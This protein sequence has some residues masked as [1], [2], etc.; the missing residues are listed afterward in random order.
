MDYSQ[1]TNR[2]DLAKVAYTG[3]YLDLTNHPGS[4]LDNVIGTDP[5]R[6]TTS[7]KFRIVELYPAYSTRD[8]YLTKEDWVKFDSKLSFDGKWSSLTEVPLFKQ[9]AFSG[10]YHDLIN[11]PIIEVQDLSSYL[12]LGDTAANSLLLNGLPY[13]YFQPAGTSINGSG[14]STEIA[15]FIN[16]NTI[17]SSASLTWDGT[18]LVVGGNIRAQGDVLAFDGAAPINWWL[19]MPIAEVG[20]IGGVDV[21][22]DDTLFLNGKGNWSAAGSGGSS[23]TWPGGPGIAVYSGSSSWGTS[24]D[25]ANNTNNYLTTMTGTGFNGEAGLT[26][27]GSILLATGDIKA[28]GR[29][30]GGGLVNL[31]TAIMQG[32]IDTTQSYQQFMSFKDEAGTIMFS[33]GNGVAAGGYFPVFTGKVTSTYPGLYFNGNCVNGPGSGNPIVVFDGRVNNAAASATD[34]I[35]GFSSGYGNLKVTV[36]G[37]GDL[38]TTGILAAT[39]G[40]ST[41]WNTAYT[42]RNKWDGG[43]SGLTA[44]TGRSSLGLGT[45]A[46]E[47]V[48]YFATAS[49]GS[50]GATAYG[51]GN[52]ASVGYYIG[53]GSAFD[54]AGAASGAVG[55]HESTYNHSNFQDA[56]NDR[57]K[58]DGGS[59]GLTAATGRT[60]LGLGSAAQNNTGDFVAYRTFGSA[61]NNNT[62]DFVAYRTFND[63]NWDT[64]YT[65]RMKWDG[66]DTGLTASTGRT[67]LGLNNVTNESK[68]TMF[69][70]PVFTTSFGF[71]SGGWRFVESGTDILF[72][73]NN[74]TKATLFSNGNLTCTG[75]VTA[76]G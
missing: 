49:Q 9:V 62:G 71:S 13:N 66:G 55:S 26:Y 21:P 74:V 29:V 22:N 31:S 50:Q 76:F 37:N 59:T 18:D 69:S 47:N 5:V 63:S 73:Y 32:L 7:G 45:A 54:T 20:I 39:G 70:S 17:A 34:I 2:P 3:S 14:V 52:H 25:I 35:I 41:N 24:L 57:M 38:T 19:S 43:S 75:E 46:V 4:L 8:G 64:A 60:S 44:A 10:D 56:Y 67:S 51:W 68:A 30:I 53:T 40:S 65:D 6:V 11:K 23:M 12:T 61:A 27:D 28:S 33:V 58:W 72:K 1:I 42:D 36:M 48:G 16:N 15:I